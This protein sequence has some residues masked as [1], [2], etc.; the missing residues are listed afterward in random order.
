[1]GNMKDYDCLKSMTGTCKDFG[2]TATFQVPGMSCAE[3]GAAMTSAATSL[4]ACQTELAAANAGGPKKRQRRVRFCL[5]ENSRLLPA[6]TEEV[7]QSFNIYM[8]SKVDRCVYAPVTD[9]ENQIDKYGR[10]KQ[11]FI[12]AP[13][14]HPDAK[15]VAMKK[16]AFGE[17]QERLAFQFFEVAADGVTVVGGPK[18]AKESRFIDDYV[19]GET[20]DEIDSASRDKF[21]KRFC[22]I[23]NQAKAVAE[24]F[25]KK[26]D[27]ISTLDP[28][29]PRV[30]FINCCVYYISD[31]EHGEKSVIVE[32]KLD[33]N[34]E[35]WNNNNGV[36]KD[37]HLYYFSTER[38]LTIDF[39][40]DP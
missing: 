1:M 23:Q 14:Q 18:V 28:Q 17:G 33:G 2:G 9:G 27:S 31:D 7:D 37:N 21:A 6:L 26:L 4:A 11:S 3:I 30:S 5:R 12:A 24:A 29:T 34:F 13:L 38:C 16:K 15:G 20:F 36:S 32:P 40:F 22:S 35:K 25:N 10:P 39:C 19:D 8:N